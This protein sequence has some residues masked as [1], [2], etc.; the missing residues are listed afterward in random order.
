MIFVSFNPLTLI[1][2]IHLKMNIWAGFFSVL[3]KIFVFKDKWINC[4]LQKIIGNQNL[5]ISYTNVD[6]Q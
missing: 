5:Y 1:T 4:S 2:N 6:S 3:V